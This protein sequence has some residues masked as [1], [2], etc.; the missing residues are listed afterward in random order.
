MKRP[1]INTFGLTK[2]KMPL[3]LKLA[4]S[5]YPTHQVWSVIPRPPCQVW[6]ELMSRQWD[7]VLSK[8][9]WIA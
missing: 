4:A 6:A 9:S 8:G 1:S 5:T 7:P 3:T 2:D